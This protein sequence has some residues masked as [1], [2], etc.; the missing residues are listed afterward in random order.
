[1]VDCVLAETCKLSQGP[2]GRGITATVDLFPG[3]LVYKEP[4]FAFVPFDGLLFS[5]LSSQS[6]QRCIHCFGKQEQVGDLSQCEDCWVK[7]CQNCES[8]LFKYHSLECPLMFVFYKYI[9][10]NSSMLLLLLRVLIVKTYDSSGYEKILGLQSNIDKL[11]EEIASMRPAF[12]LLLNLI[13]NELKVDMETMEILLAII[14]TNTWSI[15]N[16]FGIYTKSSYFNHSCNPN[17]FVSHIGGGE[18]EIRAINDIQPEDELFAFYCKSFYNSRENRRKY[19]ADSKKFNCNCERCTNGDHFTTAWKCK[20]C[21]SGYIV[22]NENW[23]CTM[24]VKGEKIDFDKMESALLSMYEDGF[25]NSDIEQKIQSLQNVLF[26]FGNQL[27]KHHYIL[28]KVKHSLSRWAE[29]RSDALEFCKEIVDMGENVYPKY[30]KE[31]GT[32]L[33]Q[34]GHLYRSL[35]DPEQAQLSYKEALL[36]YT[37]C[38]GKNHPET[39]RLNSYID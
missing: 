18:I 26:T 6:V 39:L 32:N 1:M 20:K 36:Q 25:Y 30:W 9:Q 15:D 27:H 13:P 28:Y 12:D 22:R 23:E 16:G 38:L 5:G 17:V 19:L 31:H 14:L 8:D 4:A 2:H 34:L 29:E 7:Y 24:C 33:F 11:S 10:G 35:D 21:D 37:I 3:K